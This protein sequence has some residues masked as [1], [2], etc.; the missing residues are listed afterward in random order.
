MRQRQ[1]HIPG[2]IPPGL[3]TPRYFG[4]AVHREAARWSN[5]PDNAL[6]LCVDEKSQCQVLERTQPMLPLV[7]GMWG[8][9]S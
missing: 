2:E 5:P 1:A 8:R 7:S 3:V 4:R 6:V 9:N